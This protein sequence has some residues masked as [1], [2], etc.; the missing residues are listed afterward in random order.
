[1]HPELSRSSPKTRAAER[2]TQVSNR[3]Y[4]AGRRNPMKISR[5]N[6]QRIQPQSMLRYQEGVTSDSAPY[7]YGFAAPK[8]ARA[9]HEWTEVTAAQKR[10]LH[11]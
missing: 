4:C 7:S 2:M 8:R 3:W 11:V 1:M 6:R 10:R 5:I 9:L